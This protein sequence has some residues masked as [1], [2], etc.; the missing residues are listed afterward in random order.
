[1]VDMEAGG[2]MAWKGEGHTMRG[3]GMQGGGELIT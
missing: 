1:M 3:V 2:A